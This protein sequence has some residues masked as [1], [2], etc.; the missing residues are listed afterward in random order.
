MSDEVIKKVDEEWKRKV[1]EEKRQLEQQTGGAPKQAAPA[2]KQPPSQQQPPASR[3]P[4][5]GPSFTNLV[6]SLAT[7]AAMCL[8]LV[9]DE[10]STAPPQIDLK[11]GQ[12]LIDMLNVLREKTRGNLTAEEQAILDQTLDELRMVYVGLVQKLTGGG[13]GTGRGRTIPPPPR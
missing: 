11:Q 2:P 6:E 3:E 4:G 5:A 10:L 13:R 12:F 1:Q 9:Q 8:G 7:Q